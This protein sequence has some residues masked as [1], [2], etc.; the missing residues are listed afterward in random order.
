MLV[1]REALIQLLTSYQDSTGIRTVLVFDG[2]GAQLS[3][4]TAPG[5][6]QVFY[7][8]KGQTADAVI[9]RLVAAYA[10]QHDLTV[11]TDDNLERETTGA[12]GAYTLS[13]ET[14]RA[15]LET[16]RAEFDRTLKKHRR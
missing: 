15:E 14:F 7:A 13:T 10:G 4:E 12:F 3:E 2:Q 5:G 8:A 11:V 9:E 6:I 1:A 16:A